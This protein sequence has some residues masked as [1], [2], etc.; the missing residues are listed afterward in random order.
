MHYNTELNNHGLKADPFKAC[1]GPR[2]IAWIST[3][4]ADGVDN[5]APF[6]QFNNLSYNPPMVMVAFQPGGSEE[7]AFRKDTLNNIEETGCFVYNMVP[8]ALKDQMN[9]TAIPKHDLDEWAAAGLTKADSIQI[10]A[11]RVAES[12]IQFE[13][14][15]LHQSTSRAAARRASSTWSSPKSWRSTLPTTCSRPRAKSTS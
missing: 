15:Y 6:S 12:P 8:Y 9:I 5:L 1:V 13:C 7:E 4:S 14:K 11:K 2:P 10:P 3:V